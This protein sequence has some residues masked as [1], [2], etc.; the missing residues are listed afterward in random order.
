MPWHVALE[1]AHKKT[2]GPDEPMAPFLSA[3]WYKKEKVEEVAKAAGWKN[4]NFIQKDAYLNLGTE[5]RRWA[6]V[7]WTFLEGPVGG[8][9]QR[10]EGYGL[11]RGAIAYL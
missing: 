9:K 5:I 3:S 7:A 4:V 1:N 2:R 11:N 8:W 10:D 6:T